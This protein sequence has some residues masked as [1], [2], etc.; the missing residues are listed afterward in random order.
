MALSGVG[1]PTVHLGGSLQ[2]PAL[3][4][5]TGTAWFSKKEEAG[6]NEALVA[7]VASAINL[8][9]RHI[10]CAEVPMPFMCQGGGQLLPGWHCEGGLNTVQ[11]P[12]AAHHNEGQQACPR[13]QDE[14]DYCNSTVRSFDVLYSRSPVACVPGPALQMY[15]NE[16][17]VGLGIERSGAPRESLF[18]TSKIYQSM[19]DPEAAL[20][21]SLARLGVSHLDLYLVHA[22][23]KFPDPASMQAAWAALERCVALGLTKALG[24]SNFRV[25]DLQHI[26]ET[27][28]IPPLV[29]QVEFHPYLQTPELHGFCQR[30]GI[31]LE[32]YGAWPHPRGCWGS[33][34]P[35]AQWHCGEAAENRGPDPPALGHPEGCMVVTTTS[36][37][38][39]MKEYLE[40]GSFQLSDEDM[41]TIDTVGRQ[42]EYRRFWV[43]NFAPSML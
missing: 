38:E 24:V 31:L 11:A 20:R 23:F 32:S 33:L 15:K 26:L 19:A 13:A 41:Q 34:G 12:R 21:A 2:A 37:V 3:A 10:D 35:R 36:R 43:D 14:H 18:I 9:F 8:G 17:T 29:N 4:Y 30:N 1:V 40:V 16:K 5:G 27:A 42:K 7:S 6:E 28:T 22:P 39:R 25:Q